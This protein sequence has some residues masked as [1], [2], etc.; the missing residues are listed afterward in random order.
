MLGS[1]PQGLELKSPILKNS[2]LILV[3]NVDLFSQFL[4]K[5][6]LVLLCSPVIKAGG[7]FTMLHRSCCRSRA[8][9]P[10]PWVHPPLSA[11]PSL[12]ATILNINK[13]RLDILVLLVRE[14]C[15]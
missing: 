6:R 4:I 8:P 1:G 2:V 10:P 13:S 14:G 11:P 3:P 15:I 9:H 7:P 5:T 12:K